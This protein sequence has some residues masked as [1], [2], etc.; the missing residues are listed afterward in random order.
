MTYQDAEKLL[1]LIRL[2]YPYAYRNLDDRHYRATARMWASSFSTV[3]YPVI[4]ACFNA[5]RMTNRYAPTVAD[6]NLQLQAYR[7]DLETAMLI[8]RQLGNRAL[9]ERFRRILTATDSL[10]P[11]LPDYSD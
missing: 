4:E 1:E 11:A 10:P 2:A 5:Y 6:I 8:Q 9:E 3:P 7:R